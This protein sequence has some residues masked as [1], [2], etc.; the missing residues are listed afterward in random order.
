MKTILCVVANCLVALLITHPIVAQTAATTWSGQISYEGVRK[1]D[2]SQMRIVINGEQ[3]KPGDPNFPTDIPDTRSFGQKTL[4]NGTFAKESRDD[5]ATVVR[6]RGDGG[7][8]QT[9][10]LPRPFTEQ[11]F[12]DLQG[13]KKVTLLTVG[14]DAEAKTYQAE[15]PLQRV[16]GWQLTDQTKKIAGYTCRKATVPYKKE[17]YTVWVTTEIPV[18][19]SPIHELTPETGT[20]L[21]IEGSKEQFKAT[22]VD[23][24]SPD[25]SAVKPNAQAQTVTPEQLADL[26]QK[27]ITDFQQQLQLNERN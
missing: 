8:P 14:K 19:Y 2:P 10:N 16:S 5:Q 7:V 13:Q 3:V 24:T 15:V 20:V 23:T 26:R 22:K 11:I 21:L 9:R 1:V 27:A 6:V 25:A 17:T 12:V 4:I 18:T